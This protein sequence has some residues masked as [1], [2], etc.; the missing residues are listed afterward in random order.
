MSVYDDLEGDDDNDGDGDGDDDDDNDL[1]V[2]RNEGREGPGRE[3]VTGVGGRG[4]KETTTLSVIRVSLQHNPSIGA[5]TAD[6]GTGTGV[7]SGPGPGPGVGL[8]AAGTVEVHEDAGGTI[9]SLQHVSTICL[10]QSPQHGHGHGQGVSG[11][12][13]RA[14]GAS[15]GPAPTSSLV[16]L[17]GSTDTDTPSPYKI[18]SVQDTVRARYSQ[19]KILS[20]QDTLS[21]RYSPCKIPDTIEIHP[22]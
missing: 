8:G 9:L 1:V 20:V 10:P 21:T 7:G 22:L 2:P 15:T 11:Q 14:R 12:A 4:R 6:Q 18:L 13:G 16:L 5:I 17:R 3:G 19:Y